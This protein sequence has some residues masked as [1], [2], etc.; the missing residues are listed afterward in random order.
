MTLP[1]SS[2]TACSLIGS[3]ISWSAGDCFQRGATPWPRFIQARTSSPFITTTGGRSGH[4][5]GVARVAGGPGRDRHHQ[6]WTAGSGPRSQ[7]VRVVSRVF[8]GVQREGEEPICRP[9]SLPGTVVAHPRPHVHPYAGVSSTALGASVSGPGQRKGPP[10]PGC[11][12]ENDGGRLARRAGP[13]LADLRRSDRRVGR[14]RGGYALPRSVQCEAGPAPEPGSQAGI[15]PVYC[16][17]ASWVHVGLDPARR[18]LVITESKGG[19][20]TERTRLAVPADGPVP[21][22]LR[23]AHRGSTLHILLAGKQRVDLTGSWGPSR[24]GWWARRLSGVFD[25]TSCF[26]TGSAVTGV[27]DW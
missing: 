3:A 17:E 5:P 13:G 15:A 8:P 18:P 25:E 22:Y 4:R 16:D 6:L 2:S 11:G 9:H 23:T 10:G 24:V 19:T 20:T 12:M 26:Q 14:G 21:L 7:W 1:K 27:S